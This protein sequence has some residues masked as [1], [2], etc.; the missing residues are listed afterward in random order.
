M[1]VSAREPSVGCRQAWP[2]AKTFPSPL[3]GARVQEN[4]VWNK[5]RDDI[6]HKGR[7]IDWGRWAIC[8]NDPEFQGTGNPDT[9]EA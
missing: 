3:T 9:G 8:S 6:E 5:Y 2:Q 1:D 4:G 7:R